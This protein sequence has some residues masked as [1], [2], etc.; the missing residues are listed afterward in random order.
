MN[1]LIFNDTNPLQASGVVGLD[2]LNG[3]KNRGHNVK[4]IV[5]AYATNYPDGIVSAETQYLLRKKE[6]LKR[7][8]RRL[9]IGNAITTDPDYHIHELFEYK[10]KYNTTK[11]IRIA[12]FKA[13]AI[14]V[15]F[16]KDFINTKNIYELSEKTN[17][18]VY[19]LM[20]D[21]APLTGGCHYAWDCVGYQNKC[22]N[23]PGLFSSNPFDITFKN[24]EYKKKYIDRTNIQ[25][26][27]ASEWQ[28]RQAKL[29][30]LFKDKTIHKILL[31]VDSTLFKPVD[32]EKLREE[33]GIPLTKKIIFFGSVYMNHKRK[34]MQYLLEGLKY[35]KEL[36][37]GTSLEND[38][39]LLIAGRKIEEIVEHLPFDYNFLG[40]LDNTKGIA[41]AYQAADVF[42]SPSIEDSGPSMIN[43]SIMCGTPVVSFEMGVALDLVIT[44]KTGYRAILKASDDLAKGIYSVLSMRKEKYDELSE[45][46][47]KLALE[48]CAPEVQIERF[49]SILHENN[50]KLNG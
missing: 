7:I 8:R 2:L 48:F 6:I 50:G 47:R 1:I 16:A 18:P 31:S 15:L 11:L 14:I 10:K 27:A 44:G 33:L 24:L 38:I 22:G 42:I 32:K 37:K 21:M 13:D 20:Y 35:L 3:F 25:L 26:I 46:C 39:Y 30:S 23:C 34:G 9:N 5:N 36:I 45:S 19:W 28:Y 17:T 49:E 40:M 4:L 41:S 12:K 29:S 43:Q